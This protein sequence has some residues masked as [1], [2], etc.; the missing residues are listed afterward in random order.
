VTELHGILFIIEPSSVLAEFVAD[1]NYAIAGVSQVR[2][3]LTLTGK[4]KRGFV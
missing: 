3:K 2:L 4:G 1:F